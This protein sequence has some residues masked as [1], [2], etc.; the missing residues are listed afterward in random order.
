M[1]IL[2]LAA[3]YG[4]RLYP[5]TLN[6]P[7][8]LVPVCNKPLLNFLIEKIDV[9]K[10]KIPV[11]SIV[12]VSNNKFYKDFLNWKKKYKIEVD[13]VNDGSTS[14]DDRLGAVKDMDFAISGK[15]DDWLILGGDNLFEDNLSRFIEFAHKKESPC[16]VV[17]DVKDKKSASRYGVVET[18]DKKKITKL[19]EKPKKPFSTLVAT[20]IYFFPKKSLK[21]L[22]MFL[23]TEKNT[24]AAGKYIKWLSEKTEVYGYQLSGSWTDIGHIDSLMVA[25]REYRQLKESQCD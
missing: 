21:F 3:G 20:C 5:L 10:E 17:Y 22:G 1:R 9:L 2:I 14:P 13:I 6:L 11:K 24:D 7:K 19:E 18:D 8:S 25:E 23:K 4:T 15:Q 16:V 12:V